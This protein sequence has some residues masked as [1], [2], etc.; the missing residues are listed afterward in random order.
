MIKK[1]SLKPI[2]VLAILLVSVLVLSGCSRTKKT[3]EQ[4]VFA[5]NTYTNTEIGLKLELP[6]GWTAATREELD[7]Y[8]NPDIALKYDAF[9]KRDDASVTVGIDMLNNMFANSADVTVAD[10]LGILRSDV[11]KLKLDGT[12]IG[13]DETCVLAGQEGGFLSIYYGDEQIFQEYYVFGKDGYMVV[14]IAT[15]KENQAANIAEIIAAFEA[16]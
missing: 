15:Y 2:Y 8:Q 13:E 5:D 6:E 4:G 1:K 14:I 3:V 11:K 10:Y 9:F 7:S 16:V 12:E